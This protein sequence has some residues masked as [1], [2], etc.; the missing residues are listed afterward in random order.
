MWLFHQDFSRVVQQAWT[1]RGLQDAIMEF[2]N[3]AKKGN[4]D[5]FGNLFAK[6]KRLLARLHGAQK[7]LANNPNE[8]LLELE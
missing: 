8:F 5:V 3:R 2:V 6:K 4:V 1:D 7:A